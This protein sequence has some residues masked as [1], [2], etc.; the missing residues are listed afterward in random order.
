VFSKLRSYRPSHGTVV[1]YIALFVALGGTSYGV[2]TG[3]IGSR[4]IKNNSI[5]SKDIRNNTVRGKDIRT[6]TIRSSDVGNGSLLAQDFAAGQLP[7][8]PRGA[9]GTTGRQ[10]P[11]GPTLGVT[12]ANVAVP[13]QELSLPAEVSVTTPT[14]GK[15]FVTADVDDIGVAVNCT[16]DAAG[17]VALYVD[18]TPIT[19]TRRDVADN[20]SETY[21]V[22]GVSGTVAAGTRIVKLGVSCAG[23]STPESWVLGG[24]RSLSAVLLGS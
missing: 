19:G 9:T 13:A 1:A 14:A 10:G 22:S 8:G 3:S 15:L 21:H 11:P 12:E 24:E 23:A 20:V 2:A 17:T 16:P 18:G 6:G 5:R 7:S 4:A